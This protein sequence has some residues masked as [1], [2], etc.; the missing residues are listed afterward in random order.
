MKTLDAKGWME[1]GGGGGGKTLGACVK[2]FACPTV[3]EKKF[4]RS[5]VIFSVKIQWR[6]RKRKKMVTQE[7]V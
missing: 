7:N 5:S 3:P 6:K 2:V 1:W 4:P